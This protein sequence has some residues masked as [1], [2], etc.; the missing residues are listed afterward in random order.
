MRG[1]LIA[2]ALVAMAGPAFAQQLDPKNSGEQVQ[3]YLKALNACDVETIRDIIDPAISSFGVRGQFAQS[4]Q[5]YVGALQMSCRAGT[6]MKLQPKILRQDE[7]GDVALAAVEVTGSTET[8]GK[9]TKADLRLT[10]VLKRDPA[11]GVWRIIH[12]QTATAF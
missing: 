12:S 11:D 2:L 1:C 10:L 8:A 6:K 3:R 7:F 5:V 4:K 9:T